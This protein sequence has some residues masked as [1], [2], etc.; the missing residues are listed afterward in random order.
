MLAA[1]VA[2]N[3]HCQFFTK[4]TTIFLTKTKQ[5]QRNSA[6]LHQQAPRDYLLVIPT[7]E[8]LKSPDSDL[9]KLLRFARIRPPESRQSSKNLAKI[10]K[11]SGKNLARVW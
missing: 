4:F 2:T 11:E 10:W 1:V 3:A 9:S 5:N 7:M 8:I 6:F